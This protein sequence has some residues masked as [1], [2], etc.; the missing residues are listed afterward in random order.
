MRDHAGTAS[1]ASGT[2]IEEGRA[3]NE[4]RP[5]AVVT[6]T[7]PVTL[8]SFHRELIRQVSLTHDVHVISSPGHDL[9]ELARDLDVTPHPLPMTREISPKLDLAALRRWVT[10]LK[11]IGPD[12]IVTATPKASLLGQLAARATGVPKRL[13]YCGG[14]RLEGET[15]RRRQLLAAIERLTG[16]AATA[17]VV[18]SPSLAIRS[19]ELNL[20]R[21]SK[22]FATVPAS[23]HG[24]DSEHFAPRPPDVSLRAELGLEPDVPVLGFVGRLTHDKG[25]DTLIAGVEELATR[26]VDAQLLVVG[27]QDEPDSQKYV[28]GLRAL[29]SH[30]VLAGRQRDVR[31]YFSLMDIHVLPSHREGFPNVVLEAAAMAVPTV[32]TRATGC[33]DSV[34][35][36][37]TGRLHD[38]S[39]PVGF[40][41]AVQD[42]LKVEKR[43]SYAKAA[44]AWASDAF[45]PAAVVESLLAPLG[46]TRQRRVAHVINSLATGGAERLIVD[47]VS[48]LRSAGVDAEILALAPASGP[49]AQSAS[50]RGVPVTTLG[51]HRFDPRSWLRLRNKAQTFDVIHAHLFP[52]FWAAAAVKG[53]KIL[54]EHS[55]TNSRRA[56]PGWAWFERGIYRRFDVHV[57]ISKG[58]SGALATYLRTPDAPRTV[59]NGIDFDRFSAEP[60]PRGPGPLKVALVGTLDSRKAVDDAIRVVAACPDTTLT[61]IGDGPDRSKLEAL[62]AQ[63]AP[64]RVHFS[65]RV[66]DVAG[67]L[68]GHHVIL[69]TSKYEGFGLAVAEAMAAGLAP[70]VPDVPGLREVVGSADYAFPPGDL[71]E[72]TRILE[73]FV[74][75]DRTRLAVAGQ[76][77]EQARK[78]SIVATVAA[79][80]QLY[81]EPR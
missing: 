65:G 3:V 59:Y 79:Y 23:S 72:A 39:D 26:G 11:S 75:H 29:N 14:L 71:T 13:Y 15:G 38:V 67:A 27:P 78:F 76:A 22:L 9:D 49:V 62:A 7:V 24:V 48:G 25:I 31:P 42:M 5:R 28:S 21:S 12:V 66:T 54:T 41:D 77:R 16:S 2:R 63:V 8:N 60:T 45:E 58:V 17:V 35:D 36:R 44:R 30:V 56:V 55:P 33:V 70:V 73:D 69:S 4:R 37:V 80:A 53:R 64:N 20:Y 46:L 43:D 40:A 32:T 81:E 1:S 52:A 51:A 18:N 50:E 6:S 57:G 47:I 68:R 10:L 74:E 61:V 19:R 34:Q